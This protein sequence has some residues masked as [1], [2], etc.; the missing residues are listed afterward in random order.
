MEIS[1][2]KKKFTFKEMNECHFRWLFSMDSIRIPSNYLV[3]VISNLKVIL[4][5]EYV[6]NPTEIT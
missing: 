1:Q 6:R 2:P 5:E 3:E 4:I